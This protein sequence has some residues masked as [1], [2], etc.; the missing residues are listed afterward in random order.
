MKQAL[1][2]IRITVLTTIRDNN[3]HVR[4]KM[5]YS[6][7]KAAKPALHMSQAIIRRFFL[8]FKQ[9]FR[10]HPGLRLEVIV[11]LT[12]SEQDFNLCVGKLKRSTFILTFI[13]S[14]C[15]VSAFS[16]SEKNRWQYYSNEQQK[17]KQDIQFQLESPSIE[18]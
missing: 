15:C 9:K 6:C 4:I 2:S 16:N 3:Q 1:I 5:L 8:K 18:I 13:T 12:R 17:R 11:P 14:Q 7:Y 10:Q